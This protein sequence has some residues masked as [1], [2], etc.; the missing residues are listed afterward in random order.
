M[1][2]FKQILKYIEKDFEIEKGIEI[3]DIEFVKLFH[4]EF[5]KFQEKMKDGLDFLSSEDFK[6][7]TKISVWFKIKKE[8]EN[9]S[10]CKNNLYTLLCV[11]QDIVGSEMLKGLKDMNGENMHEYIEKMF[12]DVE[13]SP[14]AEILKETPLGEILNDP[15]LKQKIQ[16][17]MEKLKNID[18]QGM[19]NKIQSGN[20]DIGE[21]TNL[22]G[23]IGLGGQIGDVNNPLGNAMNLVNGLMGS[24]VDPMAGL[25]PQQRAKLR[26]EQAKKEYR[27][28]IR[29]REKEKK[30]KRRSQ[31]NR[32]KR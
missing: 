15:Q 17:I 27:R 23:E 30:K 31:G 10:I 7:M 4:K 18:I 28:K 13:N 22:M 3:V 21:I 25:T 11:A 12:G 5:N 24:N 26:R 19:M 32:K 8:H 16:T 20:F 9:Y 1:E 6:I 14:L 29:A 2:S